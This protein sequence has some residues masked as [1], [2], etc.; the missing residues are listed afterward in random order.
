LHSSYGVEGRDR[1]LDGEAMLWVDPPRCE[2]TGEESRHVD[3]NVRLGSFRQVHLPQ[4]NATGCTRCDLLL[5][6]QLAMKEA[7]NGG[8]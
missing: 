6:R 2:L 3:S 4:F 5:V 8:V 1:L 7:K